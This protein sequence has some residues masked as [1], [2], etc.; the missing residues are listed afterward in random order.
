MP[1]IRS[2]GEAPWSLLEVLGEGENSQVF[3]AANA[4]IPWVN[5]VN[6]SPSARNAVGDDPVA[7]RRVQGVAVQLD[8][9]RVEPSPNGPSG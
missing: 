3:T 7:G 5:T 1:V 6:E 4:V 8:A 9:G 2:S